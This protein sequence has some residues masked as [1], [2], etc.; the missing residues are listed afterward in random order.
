MYKF[1]EGGPVKIPEFRLVNTLADFLDAVEVLGYPN[2]P[3]C[4]KPPISKGTRGFRILRDD[5]SR[6]HALLNERPINRF[7]SINEFKMPFMHYIPLKKI[8]EIS[9]H[10]TQI[11]YIM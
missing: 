6:K 4:F 8:E 5:V 2:T 7:I 1:L 11:N 10:I 3:V 9:T